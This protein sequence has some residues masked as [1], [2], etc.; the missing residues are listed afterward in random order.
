MTELPMPAHHIAQFQPLHHHQR[1]GLVSPPIA[2]LAGIG[3]G[4]EGELNAL[5]N[6][7]FP[8]S[9]SSIAGSTA[10]LDVVASSGLLSLGRGKRAA[11][12]TEPNTPAVTADG[13]IGSNDDGGAIGAD[14]RA[15]KK[16]KRNKPTLS[17]AEC[18]ERKTKVS[19][20]FASNL[21]WSF[22]RQL[23]TVW[24]AS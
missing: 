3:A 14:L 21:V 19:S 7:S 23:I 2:P 15:K 20:T 16:Q 4:G 8:P 6:R 1:S 12:S 10:A 17:C 22:Q 18:V 5:D 24:N 9:S 11:S 13:D